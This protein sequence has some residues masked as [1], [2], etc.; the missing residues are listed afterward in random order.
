[1]RHAAENGWRVWKHAGPAYA[2][3]WLADRILC[4]VGVY[5]FIVSTHERSWVMRRSEPRIEPYEFRWA[6]PDEVLAAAADSEPEW[7]ELPRVTSQLER[8]ERC[9]AAFLDGRMVSCTWSARSGPLVPGLTIN[10]P[11]DRIYGH[12]AKTRAAHR[13]KG[14]YAALVLTGAREAACKEGMDMVGYVHAGNSRALCGSM[15][16]GKMRSG[17]VVCRA[18]KRP[19]AWV[20]PACRREGVWVSPAP[21]VARTPGI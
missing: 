6:T 16:M 8:G 3:V 21:T 1:L 12:E 14:L 2:A 5:F 17:L 18:G 20:S 19:W 10:V 13:G 4:R 15:R 9:L 11:P 7:M